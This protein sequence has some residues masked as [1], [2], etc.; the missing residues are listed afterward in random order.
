MNTLL[1]ED[2][3]QDVELIQIALADSHTKDNSITHVDRIG[4][5]ME[6]LERKHF[7]AAILDLSLPDS[8]GITTLKKLISK[9]PS[10]PIIIL[11]GNADESL[12]VEAVHMG[13]QD[14]LL[15][16]QLDGRM[17]PR[18]IK[19]AIE[20]KQSNE[21]L[22]RSQDQ[23]KLE[24]KKL[25]E[26]LSVE[27]DLTRIVH[28]DKLIDFVANKTTNILEADKC[29]IMF[30][31]D[32]AREIYIKKH[33][34]LDD[35]FIVNNDLKIE[36]STVAFV[37]EKGI[38]VLVSNIETDK[39]FSRKNRVSYKSKSFM[40][41]PIKVGDEIFGVINVAD[42][43]S[44]EGDVFTAIDLKV[45]IMLV[46]QVAVA[47]ENAKL[48]SKLNYLT[49]TD[50]LTDMYNLRYFTKSLNNEINR[51]KRH[52]GSLCLLVLDIDDFKSYND[53]F[54]HLAG[55]T[56]L[57]KIS[58]ILKRNLRTID[59]ACRYGGDEF[60]VILP[61][62]DLSQ[63]KIVAEKIK[64]KVAHLSLRTKV[65]VSIGI[66]DYKKNMGNTDLFQNAD[67]ALYKAKKSGKNTVSVH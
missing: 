29:S 4:K 19:Y 21:K 6:Q 61:E 62:T 2:D 56:L 5:A 58:K 66:A 3:P 63:A 42:K 67:S 44:R 38:P 7:D 14:Y 17:L 27:E 49:I 31:N 1:I 57:K 33:I 43:N 20:R 39:R 35:R 54:G 65:T 45:L 36:D 48:Y 13:A 32:K 26:V 22:K 15:K 10:L 24:K 60:V 25:E 64:E 46:R 12:G 11:T 53:T 50:P 41:A 23:L 59:I 16:T 55:D 47:I 52:P 40:S 51:M 37:A 34:G 18:I 28:L 9:A 8:N 30:I